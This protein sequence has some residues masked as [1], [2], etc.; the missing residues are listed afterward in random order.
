MSVLCYNRIC[1][2]RFD[3]DNNINACTFHPGV[4]VFHD[5]LKGW[6]CCKR[7]TTDF[8]DFLSIK[9]MRRTAEAVRPE[10]KTTGERKEIVEDLRPRGDHYIIPSIHPSILIRLSGTPRYLNSST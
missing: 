4:P 7:R 1:G 8:S 5:A 2:Q 10:V 9:V 6:S 3:P